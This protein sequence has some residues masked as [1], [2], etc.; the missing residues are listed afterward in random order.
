MLCDGGSNYFYGSAHR[1]SE[2]VKAIVG[3]LDS[4]KPE[5]RQYYHDRDVI[6][7][8]LSFD[9]DTNDLEKCLK[10]AIKQGYKKFVCVGALGGRFDQ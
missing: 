8:D 7:L 1:D 2:K 3:D 6:I 10:Y 5:V 4:I 9:Q